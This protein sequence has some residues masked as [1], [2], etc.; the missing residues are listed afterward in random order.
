MQWLVADRKQH[1][2]NVDLALLGELTDIF[3]RSQLHLYYPLYQCFP[4][5]QA[6]NRY[7]LRA[8][9]PEQLA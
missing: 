2:A 5:C 7:Q 1:N 6:M 3:A 8:K 9:R 4:I